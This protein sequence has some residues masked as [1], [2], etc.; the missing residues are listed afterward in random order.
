MSCNLEARIAELEI[1]SKEDQ[2]RADTSHQEL[3]KAKAELAKSDDF[4]KMIDVLESG[5]CVICSDNLKDCVGSREMN[6]VSYACE[7]TTPRVVHNECWTRSF[8]C[9]CGQVKDP[10]CVITDDNALKLAMNSISYIR[11]SM[12]LAKLNMVTILGQVNHLEETIDGD[13]DLELAKTVFR[14]LKH[15]I[16]KVNTSHRNL[17]IESTQCIKYVHVASGKRV[18]YGPRPIDN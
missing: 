13:F 18:H 8:R 6:I 2:Q 3:A 16:G 10:P 17:C 11:G 9:S 7:C 15:A 5:T 4:N 14:L 12:Q 1:K